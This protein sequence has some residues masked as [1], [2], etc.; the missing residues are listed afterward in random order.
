MHASV[1]VTAS[2]EPVQRY[3][4]VIFELWVFRGVIHKVRHFAVGFSITA[5]VLELAHLF[6]A[7]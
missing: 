1:A 3:T 2:V 4:F 6:L 7:G 5:R